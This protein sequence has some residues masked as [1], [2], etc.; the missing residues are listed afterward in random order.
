MKLLRAYRRWKHRAGR[1]WCPWWVLTI[2]QKLD[3]WCWAELVAWKITGSDCDVRRN[4]RCATLTHV[5]GA[6]CLTCYC[7]FWDHE[8]CDANNPTV[9]RKA[10][11]K[12]S[13][14]TFAREEAP[15]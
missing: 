15:Q 2:A 4:T 14:S 5:D 11:L 1:W 7:G 12:A 10:Q 6:P 9:T 3:V 13:P 8:Q